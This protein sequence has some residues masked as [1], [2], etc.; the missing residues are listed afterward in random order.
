M[1][2]VDIDLESFHK[3]APRSLPKGVA[4]SRNKYC[5]YIHI[6]RKKVHLGMFDTPEQAAAAVKAERER[7]A[8]KGY[9]R[10]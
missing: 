4:R 5:A 2:K 1:R 8:G 6:N 3:I 7:L 9:V 10:P